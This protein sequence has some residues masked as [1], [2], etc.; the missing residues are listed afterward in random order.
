MGMKDRLQRL[1][2]K[3][4]YAP[5]L[6]II[7]LALSLRLFSLSE[8]A[9]GIDEDFTIEVIN[10]DFEG[11]FALVANKGVAPPAYYIIAWTI[12]NISNNIYFVKLFSAILGVLSVFI[13]YLLARDSFDEKT[14]LLASLLFS[15]MPLA[16]FYSQH[17]RTYAFTMFLYV[18]LVYLVKK[19]ND[20]R[21]GITLIYITIINSLLL[22]TSYVNA[23]II[24]SEFIYF[25]YLGLKN[26]IGYKLPFISFLMTAISFIPWLLFVS[27]GPVI[28]PAEYWTKFDLAHTGYV[29]YKFSTGVDVSTLLNTNPLL[30]LSF[31]LVMALFVSGL[32]NIRRNANFILLS[33]FF[34]LPFIV[35]AFI[36]L[37]VPI[38]HFRFVSYLL[39]LF[40]IILSKSY[41]D[42]KY[43]K[44]LLPAILIT[45]LFWLYSDFIYFSL[46]TKDMWNDFVGL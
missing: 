44:I 20:K 18:C 23:V 38:L 17:M 30:I 12:F 4:P 7:I 22:H 29:F 27:S 33:S 46:V 25:S 35:S 6:V 45:V 32:Y 3:A 5:V 37:I 21:T 10:S 16:L 13:V 39:P 1:Y 34:F 14:G 43:K 41:R 42:D 9:P 15:I 2:K 31:P 36:S 11:I 26:K 24:L 19:Y 40:A 28:N 8:K